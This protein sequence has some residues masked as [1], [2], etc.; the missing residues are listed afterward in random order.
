WPRSRPWRRH[1]RHRPLPRR[2]E[3]GRAGAARPDRAGPSP[4]VAQSA[5]L[6]TLLAGNTQG[7]PGERLQARLPDRLPAG[8]ADPV[9]AITDSG[10][11]ILAEVKQLP[12]VLGEGEVVFALER[13]GARVRL[14]VSGA[15]DRVAKPLRDLRLGLVDVGAQLSDLGLKLR[16]HLVQLRSGPG[17]LSG[18][19]GKSGR[20]RTFGCGHACLPP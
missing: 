20:A 5:P 8:G 4:P 13:L 16:A 19:Y 3:E 1:P 10:Q 15:A 11:R 18:A 2:R 17:F 9:A 14:V 7:R 6:L 12:G